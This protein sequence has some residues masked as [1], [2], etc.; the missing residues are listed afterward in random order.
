[1]YVEA[2]DRRFSLLKINQLHGRWRR[3]FLNVVAEPVYRQCDS[4]ARPLSE[5]L[6]YFRSWKA[7]GAAGEEISL[8]KDVDRE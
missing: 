8:L 7:W 2:L 3:G 5:N 4:P 1:M 6:C